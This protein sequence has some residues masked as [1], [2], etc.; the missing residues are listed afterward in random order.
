MSASRKREPFLGHTVGRRPGPPAIVE[1]LSYGWHL[2]R[3]V[4]LA[5]LFGL[6]LQFA[7][8]VYWA[9]GMSHDIAQVKVNIKDMT[10]DLKEKSTAISEIVALKT[11][12]KHILSTLERL[13]RAI[14][15]L[16]RPPP[17]VAPRLKARA[18]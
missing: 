10:G 5:L 7:A 16:G 3:R 1:S 6:F 9:S 4:P 18:P 2:D 17:Y 11:E 12:Q 13:E 15:R 8:G 14:E